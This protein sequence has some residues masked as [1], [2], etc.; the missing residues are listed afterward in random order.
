MKALACEPVVGAALCA[1]QG[2][3]RQT[4]ETELPLGR[5]LLCLGSRVCSVTGLVCSLPGHGPVFMALLAAVCWHHSGLQWACAQ[6]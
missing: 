3:S 6:Q 1:Q 5:A 2:S 4:G